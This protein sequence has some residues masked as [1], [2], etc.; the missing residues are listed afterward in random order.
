MLWV[1]VTLLFLLFRLAPGNP[2]VAYIDPTFTEEQQQALLERF[3]L[4]KPLHTQYFIYLKNLAAGDLGDSF[5]QRRPVTDLL[6][7]ALPNTLYLTLGALLIAYLYGVFAGVLFAWTRGSK[8]EKAGV[9]FTLMSRAAPEF[10]VGMLLLT[11]FSFTLQWLPSSGATSPGTVYV[12]EWAK[13][14]SLDFWAHL[15]L[16]ATTLAF[17]LHGLPLLLMRSNMLDVMKKDFVTF[18]R[19]IGYSETRLMFRFAARNALLPVITALA[20]GVGYALGGNV[21]IEQVFGWPGLG[22]TLVRAVSASDYPLAQG[23]FF[24]IAV[25]MVFLNLLADLLYRTLDPR[26][27]GGT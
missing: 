24:C 12:S 6:L 18:G 19:I 5:F 17:Y 13:I 7:E 15:I 3:G 27:Q 11:V 2:L 21:V 20:L 8:L 10:W 9:S 26:V 14:T 16:P 4:D 1:V 25:L 22:R 23:A